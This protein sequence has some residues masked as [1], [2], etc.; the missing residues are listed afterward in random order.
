M[1]SG[2]NGLGP[3]PQSTITIPSTV[4]GNSVLEGGGE[5]DDD[6]DDIF[7]GGQRQFSL[8]EY[9]SSTLGASN[10]SPSQSVY[11]SSLLHFPLEQMIIEP[12]TINSTRSFQHAPLFLQVNPVISLHTTQSHP[13]N[14][15]DSETS[16]LWQ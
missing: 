5:L 8:E 16:H 11:V 12:T 6:N 15:F 9:T 13:V 3:W 10:T 4:G 14:S 7:V 2:I 1:A